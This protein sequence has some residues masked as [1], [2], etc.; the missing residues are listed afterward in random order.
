MFTVRW[1]LVWKARNFFGKFKCDKLR[2]ENTKKNIT[3]ICSDFIGLFSYGRE[4]KNFEAYAIRAEPAGPRPRYSSRFL[5][6]LDM[7]T[8]MHLKEIIMFSTLCGSCLLDRAANVEI[9][10]EYR[11]IFVI[12]FFNVLWNTFWGTF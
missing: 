4:K 5:F 1:Y 12:V 11:I 8:H 7:K 9:G 3:T 6:K 2:L 10:V